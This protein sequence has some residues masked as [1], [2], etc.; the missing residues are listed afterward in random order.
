MPQRLFPELEAD[1]AQA[2][3]L[4]GIAE[5][6]IEYATGCKPFCVTT[7]P[8]RQRVLLSGMGCEPGQQDLFPTD[9]ESPDASH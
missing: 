1:R 6:L 5:G 8:C 2:L 7:S 9:G 3:R 4:A